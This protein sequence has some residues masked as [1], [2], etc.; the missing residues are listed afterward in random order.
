[1]QFAPLEDTAL[2]ASKR[3]EE[4]RTTASLIM[5]LGEHLTEHSQ[6]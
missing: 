3:D 2:T 4:M 1:M 6:A 5:V